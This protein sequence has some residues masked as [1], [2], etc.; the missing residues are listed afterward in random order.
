MPIAPFRRSRPDLRSL[1]RTTPLPR[2]ADAALQEVSVLSPW[3]LLLLA[4][5]DPR[6]VIAFLVVLALALF[7]AKAVRLAVIWTAQFAALA[8]LVF[9][10]FFAG[11]A[12]YFAGA[13]VQQSHAAAPFAK[14]YPE[15]G[16]ALGAIA[17][18]A[19]G[20]LVL[21]VFFIFLEILNN[22]RKRM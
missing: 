14:F 8:A 20:S 3:D 2:R 15:L 6:I 10:V 18:F 1:R 21:T 16:V 19:A 11:M 22:T 13:S 7:F 5:D 17:G 4:I 9:T 12:G